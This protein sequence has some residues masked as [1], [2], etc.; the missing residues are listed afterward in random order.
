MIYGATNAGKSSL[1]NRL[2]GYERVIVS[3]THGTT[4]DTI[5]EMINLRGVPVRLL[6]TAGLRTSTSKLEREGIARTEKS[7]ET[8]DLR[9][10]IVDRNAPKPS[11]FGKQTANG[12][13]IVLLNKS[14]LS[15]HSDWKNFTALRISCQTGEGL[16][17]LEKEILARITTQNLRP[18][19]AVTINLRHRDCLRRALQACDRARKT[20]NDGLAP[21][22]FSVDLNEALRAVGEV[23]GASWCRTD[24]RF[25]LWPV[26]H[27]QMTARRENRRPARWRTAKQRHARHGTSPSGW[28]TGSVSAMTAWKAVFRL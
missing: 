10:H 26:L 2:L 4:R 8:A 13:E 12:N 27:R 1:L 3:E 9:L 5:E 19:S 15:E 7:L 22:Y 16:A 17:D 24:S 25:C 18:E 14:D 11:H 23:I 28:R 6:D 20:M 21:E